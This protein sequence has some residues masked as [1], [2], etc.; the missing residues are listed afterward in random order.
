MNKYLNSNYIIF[1]SR[2]FRTNWR[3]KSTSENLV[4][5]TSFSKQVKAIQTSGRA[6]KKI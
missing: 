3:I 5:A 2:Y 4:K 1:L 6:I